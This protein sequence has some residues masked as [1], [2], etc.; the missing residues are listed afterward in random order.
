MRGLKDLS[1]SKTGGA[2]RFARPGPGFL[3]IQY[4]RAYAVAV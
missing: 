3:L 4:E 1:A 2:V